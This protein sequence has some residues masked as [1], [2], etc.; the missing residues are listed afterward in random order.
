MRREAGASWSLGESEIAG[1]SEDDSDAGDVDVAWLAI[2]AP[3]F[4]SRAG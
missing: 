2:G 4:Q 3:A 1:E